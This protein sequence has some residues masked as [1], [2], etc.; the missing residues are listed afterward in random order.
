MKKLRHLLLGALAVSVALTGML[1][2]YDRYR[3]SSLNAQSL[4]QAQSVVPTAQ[5]AIG[6]SSITFT[7]GNCAPEESVVL[8]H[9][10]GVPSPSAYSGL[11]AHL[12]DHGVT[13]HFPLYQ[14]SFLPH[15]IADRAVRILDKDAPDWRRTSRMLIGHSAG[16]TASVDLA[17]RELGSDNISDVILLSP[18]DGTGPDGKRAATSVGMLEWGKAKVAPSMSPELPRF[19]IFVSRNDTIVGDFTARRIQAFL[20]RS[21]RTSNVEW[22]EIPENIGGCA[23]HFWPLGGTPNFELARGTQWFARVDGK[24]GCSDMQTDAIDRALWGFLDQVLDSSK[25]ID[26][27]SA[28]A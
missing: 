28:A 13:V 7:C 12:L 8:L 21:V 14:D 1:L 25:T 5:T 15:S 18:G 9:A 26:K 6:E 27:R 24:G 4:A 20:R 2:G 17:I 23:T 22:H 19:H 16:A 3:L 11:I 10:W